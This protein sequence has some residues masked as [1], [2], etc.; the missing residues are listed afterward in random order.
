MIPPNKA[1]ASL[2]AGGICGINVARSMIPMAADT[3][4]S[5]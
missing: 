4:E 2:P 3:K 5:T 1:A